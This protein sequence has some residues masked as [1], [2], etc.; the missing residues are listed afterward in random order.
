MSLSVEAPMSM[1]AVSI[2]ASN[3]GRCRIRR[4]WGICGRAGRRQE[5][6]I[7]AVSGRRRTA[8]SSNRLGRAAYIICLLP[9]SAR[10]RGRGCR[11][12]TPSPLCRCMYTV[13]V[14]S[15]S[16]GSVPAKLRMTISPGRGA[17]AALR[18]CRRSERVLRNDGVRMRR[19]Q[20]LIRL[21]R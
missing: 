2:P 19:P 6:R 10:C 4:V 13:S 18:Q 15:A 3:G 9:H 8:I 7:S 5:N 1:L 21:L 12:R 20:G 16:A 14:Q 17:R 11:C